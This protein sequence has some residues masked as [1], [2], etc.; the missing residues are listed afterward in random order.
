[1]FQ[2]QKMT[3]YYIK[4]DLNF[5]VNNDNIIINLNMGLHSDSYEEK[6]NEEI[7]NLFIR[8]HLKK[9][10]IKIT[11]N[12][13]L[14]EFLLVEIK[15]IKADNISATGH[16]KYKDPLLNSNTNNAKDLLRGRF[17]EDGALDDFITINLD[18]TNYL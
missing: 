16:D 6:T 3:N 9:H 15:G 2:Y 8:N 7:Y 12:Q 10:K 11:T 18:T 14:Y 13:T 17:K 4:Y 1:M 5:I